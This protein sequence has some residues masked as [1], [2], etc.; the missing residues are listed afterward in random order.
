MYHIT[1]IC[2]FVPF[3]F[4]YHGYNFNFLT[5][6]F[7]ALG[8]IVSLAIHLLANNTAFPRVEY[9]AIANSKTFMTGSLVSNARIQKYHLHS[10]LN[11]ISYAVTLKIQ[12]FRIGVT[13]I[14]KQI[15][16]SLT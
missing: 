15:F 1:V 10:Q 4:A 14:L 16:A 12:F 13:F 6:I 8:K 9:N 11:T 2:L 7:D 5:R 3:L